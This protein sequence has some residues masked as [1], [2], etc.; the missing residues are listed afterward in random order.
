MP[1]FPP[2]R[3]APRRKRAPN[4]HHCS[5]RG[6]HAA[7]AQPGGRGLLVPSNRNHRARVLHASPRRGAQGEGGGLGLG[8]RAGCGAG[9]TVEGDS[10]APQPGGDHRGAATTGR[11]RRDNGWKQRRVAPA[12]LQPGKPAAA[13]GAPPRLPLGLA[14]GGQPPSRS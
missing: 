9:T 4:S 10:P 7:P 12:A 5:L 11:P 14:P 8:L 3:K 13:A 2:L 6:K 1:Q